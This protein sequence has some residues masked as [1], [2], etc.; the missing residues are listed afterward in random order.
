MYELRI[1]TGPG[2][3]VYYRR[4]G[5]VTY[6]LLCGGDEWLH[7]QR[8]VELWDAARGLKHEIAHIRPL[9]LA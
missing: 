2:Y 1:H 7:L 4:Q 8:N 3:R 9:Q 5:N 6:W